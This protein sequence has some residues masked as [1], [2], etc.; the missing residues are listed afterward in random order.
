MID[1]QDAHILDVALQQYKKS[2]FKE[3]HNYSEEDLYRYGEETKSIMLK[4]DNL[5]KRL[6]EHSL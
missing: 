6:W 2:L 3:L 4:V 5:K 1:H